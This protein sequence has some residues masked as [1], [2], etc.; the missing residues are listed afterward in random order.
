MPTPVDSANLLLKLY[1]L[2]R[3]AAMRDARNYVAGLDPQSFEELQGILMGPH[4]AHW[5]MVTSYWEMAASF[6]VNGAIDQKMF[7]EC[8][9]EHIFVFGKVE[10][11]LAQYREMM[12]NPNYLK[13][14][15]QVCANG[16]GGMER[17]RANRERMRKMMAA[18]AA[19]AKKA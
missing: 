17:V 1:E 4:S 13:S 12:G 15:E 10:P 16:P 6:V 18:R 14:L 11:F 7:D 2:R 9:G 3:E 8:N 19:A 5:R